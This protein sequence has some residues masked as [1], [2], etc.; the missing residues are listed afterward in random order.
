[1][2]LSGL[3][4]SSHARRASCYGG[5]PRIESGRRM[6]ATGRRWAPIA[7]CWRAL[8]EHLHGSVPPLLHALSLST[9]FLRSRTRS[10]PQRSPPTPLPAA[11]LH[12]MLASLHRSSSHHITEP[13]LYLAA[14]GKPP[15]QR[16][17][18]PH[19]LAA[20]PRYMCPVRLRP[21]FAMLVCALDSP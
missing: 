17:G 2:A 15:M 12:T 18:H 19:R 9:A 20:V 1:M 7:V 5:R 4:A 21:P 10:Q 16:L 11:W 8:K 14:H 6:A 3:N 13:V